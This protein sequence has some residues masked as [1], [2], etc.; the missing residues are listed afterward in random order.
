MDKTIFFDIETAGLKWTAPTIQIAAVAVENWETVDTFEVKILFDESAP[1]IEQAALEKNSYNEGGWAVDG[2]A[3][4]K[5]F[6]MF[7]DFCTKHADW[8]RLSKAQKPYK[9]AR[10]GGY[11]VAAFDIPR[12]KKYYESRN[13]FWKAAWYYPTDV[14][15]LALWYFAITK[16]AE[17]ESYTLESV[18]KYFG[19]DSEGAHDALIDCMNTV[20]V[21]R[22]ITSRI[23]NLDV[24]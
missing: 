17:T 22:Q 21:A 18:S 10:L 16:E 1:E 7:N 5:A 2:V 12:V 14:Y 11:N 15:H 23:Q 6:R 20:E 19:I 8:E 9:V 3:E 4:A 24:D 13:Q